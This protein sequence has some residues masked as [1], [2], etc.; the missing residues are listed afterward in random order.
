MKK[1]LVWAAVV[2]LFG[3]GPGAAWGQSANCAKD[4]F[5]QFIAE[6]AEAGPSRQMA[7]AKFTLTEYYDQ[8]GKG[9]N[10][11]RKMA[12]DKARRLGNLIPNKAEQ[13]QNNYTLS[14]EVR[15]NKGYVTLTKDG[16]WVFEKLEYTWQSNCWYLT[17][18]KFEIDDSCR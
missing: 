7:Q 4:K 16:S 8:I 10:K 2:G 6:M 18:V 1:I 13:R 11:S 3:F 14:T 17:G 9:C 12:Q 5:D 15:G